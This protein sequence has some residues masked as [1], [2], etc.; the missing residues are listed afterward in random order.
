MKKNKSLLVPITKSAV[1]SWIVLT[2]LMFWVILLTVP[3]A[4]SRHLRL[5]EAGKKKKKSE[6]DRRAAPPDNSPQSKTNPILC[7]EKSEQESKQKSL[8]KYSGSHFPSLSEGDLFIKRNMIN[9]EI[10][11]YE[12]H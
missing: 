8:R 4:P 2:R 3:N 9:K 5:C 10:L 7:F 11:H 1:Q 12:T 6:F